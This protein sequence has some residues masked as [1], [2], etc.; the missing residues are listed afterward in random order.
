MPALQRKILCQG[1]TIGSLTMSKVLAIIQARLGS[2]RLPNKVLLQIPPNSGISM[3]EHVIRKACLATKI[4]DIHVVTPDSELVKL[5][6]FLGVNFTVKNWEGRDVLREFYEAAI[7]Y[8]HKIIVRLTADCPLLQPDII[9]KTIEKFIKFQYESDV[10][11]V[12]NT[13]E[14]T[15][16]L[17]GEGSD[18]EIVSSR[19]LRLAYHKAK[20]Q[21]DRE[22]PTLWIR[23]NCK[24][25]YVPC[26]QLGILSVNTQNDYKLICE[27]MRNY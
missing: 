15:G 24:T 21:Q 6:R 8:D 22:H 5:L 17:D 11:M 25:L 20:D 16:Q 10:D 2:V 13:D 3:L 18:V 19:V 23:R 14:S 1:T 12:Y 27:L 7:Q 4:D 26:R 9:D